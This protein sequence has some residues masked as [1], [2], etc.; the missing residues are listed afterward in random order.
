MWTSAHHLGYELLCGKVMY[1]RWSDFRVPYLPI[2]CLVFP[3]ISIRIDT[4]AANLFS[5]DEN[6]L[7]GSTFCDSLWFAAMATANQL[8]HWSR[9]Y[10]KPSESTEGKW[11][12][13]FLFIGVEA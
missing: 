1:M 8:L 7:G 11:R 3:A 13:S 6:R 12:L 10:T 2:F 9:D 5:R 4:S